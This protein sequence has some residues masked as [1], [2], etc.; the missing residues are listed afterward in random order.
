MTPKYFVDKLRQLTSRL[1]NAEARLPAGKIKVK[2]NPTD[3][4]SAGAYV[5]K[6]VS[7][8]GA[9]LG[10]AIAIAYEM[11]SA[12]A[13]IANGAIDNVNAVNV[14]IRNNHGSN[15]LTLAGDWYVHVIK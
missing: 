7:V 2:F 1:A 6:S 12:E 8:P 3:T 10:D 15:A 13:I 14:L 4:I 5:V 11:D 9:A